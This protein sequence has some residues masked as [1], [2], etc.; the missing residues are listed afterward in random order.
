M[1]CMTGVSD[2][3]RYFFDSIFQ[4]RLLKVLDGSYELSLYDGVFLVNKYLTE[5]SVRYLLIGKSLDLFDMIQLKCTQYSFLSPFVSYFDSFVSF[6][7]FDID[8]RTNF[9][10]DIFRSDFNLLFCVGFDLKLELP[11]VH[12]YIM[13][14]VKRNI[15]KGISAG[16]VDNN[17]MF[18]NLGLKCSQVVK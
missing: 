12:A 9:S 1:I 10:L 8:I 13:K 16:Y 3:F 14:N 17:N 6:L 15:C 18:L 5:S 11:V 4:S 2:K 7:A